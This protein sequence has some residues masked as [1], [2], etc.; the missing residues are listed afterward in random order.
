MS[1]LAKELMVATRIRQNSPKELSNLISECVKC[2]KKYIY[3]Y[4]LNCFAY[5]VAAAGCGIMTNAMLAGFQSGL[6]RLACHATLL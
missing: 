3:T 1:I 5:V 4:T 2:K 6:R